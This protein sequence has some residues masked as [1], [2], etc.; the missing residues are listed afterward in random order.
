MDCLLYISPI[1]LLVL[2]IFILAVG[3]TIKHFA[4]NNQETNRIGYR[5]NSLSKGF[6]RNLSFNL[7]FR[8][9]LDSLFILGDGNKCL[10]K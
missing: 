4:A 1:L 10:I 6:K 3:T 2:T 7:A 5:Y 8:Q 9:K